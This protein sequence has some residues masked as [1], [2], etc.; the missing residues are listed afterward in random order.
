[1][2]QVGEALWCRGD[3]PTVSSERPISA[4]Q[5]QGKTKFNTTALLSLVVQLYRMLLYTLC[6]WT[7]RQQSITVPAH[8]TKIRFTHCAA[9]LQ[10][11]STH[12]LLFPSWTLTR[13]THFW[14][15]LS[16]V[17]RCAAGDSAVFPQNAFTE[18][19]LIHPLD[20]DLS[21]VKTWWYD[22]N[23]LSL[24]LIYWFQW[25]LHWTSGHSARFH[26]AGVNE[27]EITQ[28][29]WDYRVCGKVNKHGVIFS[30]L[31]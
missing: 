28:Y 20:P 26:T 5:H 29:L 31:K 6:N 21:D 25:I 27:G 11:S 18:G 8:C 15:I 4:I 19:F 7:T 10:C 1:M 14:W 24:P 9:F 2:R 3:E 16:P 17:P 13:R 30:K 12:S 22:V 23:P